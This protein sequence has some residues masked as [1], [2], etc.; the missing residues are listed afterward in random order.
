MFFFSFYGDHVINALKN[1]SKAFALRGPSNRQNKYHDCG[2]EQRQC[3]DDQDRP[4]DIDIDKALKDRRNEGVEI[5]LQE[6]GENRF[7]VDG[8]TNQLQLV[9]AASDSLTVPRKQSPR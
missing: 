2:I 4:D 9:T 7:I 6:S 5:C 3:G 8:K 1:S